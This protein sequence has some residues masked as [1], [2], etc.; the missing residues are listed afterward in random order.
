VSQQEGSGSTSDQAQKSQNQGR[1]NRHLHRQ[2]K[3]IG[4]GKKK[5]LRDF[6]TL[7]ERAKKKEKKVMLRRP[8]GSGKKKTARIGLAKDIPHGT[9]GNCNKKREN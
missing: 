3:L 1:K 4:T 5:G 6:L 7:R 2:G 8:P 9:G